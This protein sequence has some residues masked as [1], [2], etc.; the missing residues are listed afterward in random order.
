MLRRMM[1]EKGYPVEAYA[2]AAVLYGF[3]AAAMLIAEFSTLDLYYFEAW[4]FRWIGGLVGVIAPPLLAAVW[5]VRNEW[6]TWLPKRILA[7][8]CL[9]IAIAAAG[10]TIRAWLHI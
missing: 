7:G 3:C 4:S 2:M 6:D 9:G 5:F 8:W 10:V 1:T